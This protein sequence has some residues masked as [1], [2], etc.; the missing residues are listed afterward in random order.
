VSRN[1]NI[2]WRNVSDKEK[3]INLS[4]T[5]PLQNIKTSIIK[6]ILKRSNDLTGKVIVVKLA[7]SIISNKQLLTN[8]AENVYL[9]GNCGAKIFIIHDYADLIENSLENLGLSTNFTNMVGSSITKNT[10][11]VEMIISGY[12]NKIIVSELCDA[13]CNAI[14]LSGKDANLIQVQNSKLLPHRVNSDIINIGLV[15]EPGLINTEVLLNF[16]ENDI[17]PVISPI[18]SDSNKRT[19]LL[20]CNMISAIIASTIGADHLVILSDKQ[21]FGNNELKFDN[22]IALNEI[23]LNIKSDS[24]TSN[25]IKSAIYAIQN[26]TRLVHF[27]TVKPADTMLSILFGNCMN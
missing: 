3:G 14:G 7:S 27:S 10:Q 9:L 2:V 22:E 5:K 23:L 12:I 18:S 15:G 17:I 20:E 1:F 4:T 11:L 6:S 19:H 16:E 8:F 25:I 26:S 21:I 24:Y 13:G